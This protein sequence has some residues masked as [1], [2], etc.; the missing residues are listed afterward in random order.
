M[1][2]FPGSVQTWCLLACLSLEHTISVCS[3]LRFPLCVD[4]PSGWSPSL[5]EV[6]N[7]GGLGMGGGGRTQ[8]GEMVQA[9]M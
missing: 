5:V 9:H 4:A 6:P 1:R 8:R 3:V 7:F 2:C